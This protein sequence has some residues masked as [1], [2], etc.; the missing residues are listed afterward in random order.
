MWN[1]TTF[2]DDLAAG[3]V[4]DVM[5]VPPTEGALLIENGY[6][7]DMTPMVATWTRMADLNPN[8]LAPYVRDGRT[9]ALPLNVYI[10]G[11]LLDR[12]LFRQAGLVDEAGDPIA[13]DTWEEFVETAKTIKATT[14]AA[15]FCMFTRQNQGGWTFLNWGWQAG[16]DFER[17]EGGRWKATFDEPPVVAALQ[18]IK[19]LH[20]KHDVLQ[21][22]LE[23]DGSQIN[24]MIMDHKCGMA[25]AV[26]DDLGALDDGT[27]NLRLSLLPAGPGG[28]ASVMGGGYMAINTKA[29]PEVR[30]A[31]WE[32][33]RWYGYSGES[34]DITIANAGEQWQ[35]QNSTRH[36]LFKPNSESAREQRERLNLHHNLPFFRS[37]VE[38]AAQYAR[39][40][41]PIATQDLYR[42]LDGV[43]MA[44][45]TDEN[46]DPQALL[47]E[48]AQ[49]FQTQY[50]DPAS[51]P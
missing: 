18:F 19:D 1:V 43:I 44:V 35:G 36:L 7:V 40:E 9:Y 51:A 45:L 48:A 46:A 47:M 38:A 16:G 20:W 32:W 8:V 49:E 15:G 42:T 21:D 24:P 39:P 50:L 5:T 23:L 3:T 37:Y 17:Q 14:G 11:L 29:A 10:M 33:I 26:A 4:P 31:A 2:N 41:P 28:R 27:D 13:P 22:Q 25:I 6:I 34:V 30:Q 12:T